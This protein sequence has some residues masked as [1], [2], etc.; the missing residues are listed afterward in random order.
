[1]A[2]SVPERKK[3]R[4]EGKKERRKEGRKEGLLLLLHDLLPWPAVHFA[5]SQGANCSFPRGVKMSTVHDTKVGGKSRLTRGPCP[6]HCFG[7]D[8]FG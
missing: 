6:P 1:M 7:R 2:I 3:G 5:G 4:K 8:G